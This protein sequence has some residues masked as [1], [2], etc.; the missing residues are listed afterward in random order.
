MEKMIIDIGEK[1]ADQI[2]AARRY[3]AYTQKILAEKLNVEQGEVSKLESGK[4]NMQLQTLQSI[5]DALDMVVK[6]ELVPKEAVEKSGVTNDTQDQ[7]S[8]HGT[9]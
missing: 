7:E 8:G 6:I 5:A 4:R 3:R 1:A 2:A 9:I